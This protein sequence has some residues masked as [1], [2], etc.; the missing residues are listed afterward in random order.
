[1][2]KQKADSDPEDS[3]S[4]SLS[5]VPFRAEEHNCQAGGFDLLTAFTQ[6]LKLNLTIRIIKCYKK[7]HV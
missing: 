3:G 1:M 7:L 4:S 2:F 6:H 5:L